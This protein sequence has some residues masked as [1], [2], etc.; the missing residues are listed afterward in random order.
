M[1]IGIIKNANK[2]KEKTKIEN[3]KEI[4][5]RATVN[6][7]GKN[8]YGDLKQ[9]ELQNQLDKEAE[10]ETEATDVG[11]EFEIL[12]K[13]SNRYYTVDKDGNISKEQTLTKIENAG[14]ITKNNQYD[15]SEAKPY[16]ISCI[17]DLVA[18][19]NMAQGSGIIYQNGQIQNVSRKT[20]FSGK[21]IVLTRELNFKSNYSYGDS[22]RT[23]FGDL[24]TNETI[25][26]IKEELT[27]TDEGCIGFTPIG[28]NNGN[29]NSYFDGNNNTIKNIYIHRKEGTVALFCN[30]GDVK[31]LKLTGTIINDTW[32]AGG[33]TYNA[34]NIENCINYANVVGYNFVG[35]LC[36][37]SSNYIT[38]CVNYGNITVTGSAYAYGAAGGIGGQGSQKYS[39]CINYG[40]VIGTKTYIGGI[41]GLMSTSGETIVDLCKNYGKIEL[42]ADGSY[43]KTAGGIT[44]G[45]ARR[46]FSNYEFIQL[47]RS[48]FRWIFRWNNWICW[49]TCMG[50]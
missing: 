27:K 47:W 21:Y 23:D 9:D 6:A 17:E 11:N 15:G 32:E 26:T 29:K 3:E 45:C 43:S 39:N 8:K 16:Q 2:A 13:E 36:A 46:N 41:C 37:R 44:A 24:N 35:G 19:S 49:R 40:T 25:E 31:N 7:I 20:D 5:Q 28:M 38:N 14:D 34:N 4:V 30:V 1:I 12:F 10:G 42:V 50:Y 33:I 48:K 22:T 18:W